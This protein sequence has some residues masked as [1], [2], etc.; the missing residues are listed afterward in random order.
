M[1]RHS[2]LIKLLLILAVCTIIF[3]VKIFLIKNYLT[4]D[5][6]ADNFTTDISERVENKEI[7]T[8]PTDSTVKIGNAVVKIDVVDTPAERERG[9]SGHP[10]L[11]NDE[12]LFFIFENSGKYGF[13]MKDMLFSIDIIWINDR[14]E[15]VYI[16]KNATPAS[17][18]EVF[19]P[20]ADAKYVL[21]VVSGFADEN[22]ISVGD[23]VELFIS[24]L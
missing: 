18:P 4:Q 12:G 5:V 16:K 20:T 9:L 15:I 7:A 10:G 13:W 11:K 22:N 19:T 23:K 1:N 2:L 21:E 6:P 24:H 3:F 8:K 14:E 17:Y